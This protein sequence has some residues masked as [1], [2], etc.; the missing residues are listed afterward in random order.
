[1]NKRYTIQVC[2]KGERYGHPGEHLETIERMLRA[3]QFG[4][5]NPMFCTYKGTKH[6]VHSR[7]GDL[8]DPFRRT[9]AY[10]DALYIELAP[11]ASV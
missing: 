11:E 9:D 3:E 2:R 4:N 10:A 1:M 8:S 7:L 5:F 6:L